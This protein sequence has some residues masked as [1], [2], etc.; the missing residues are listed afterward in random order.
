M[1]TKIKFSVI[2]LSLLL[3][4]L[5]PLSVM[6]ANAMTFDIHKPSFGLYCNNQNAEINGRIKYV[7]DADGN[8]VQHSEYTIN[9]TCNLDFDIPFISSLF[10]FPELDISV[11]GNAVTKEICYGEPYSLFNVEP[12]YNFY[13]PN[14]DGIMGTVYTLTAPSESFTVNF[15]TLD[16]QNFIYRFTNSYTSQ[17]G[18]GNFSYTINNAQ[19]NLTY[20]IFAINGEFAELETTAETVKETIPVKEYIDRNFAAMED[21]F[22]GYENA[23]PDLL[24]ALINN[25]IEK[26]I[27]YD[28]FNFF[29]DSFSKQRVNAY[30]VSVKSNDLPCI[31][32]YS[33]PVYVLTNKNFEPAIYLTEQTATGNYNLDYT[34]KLNSELPF[35]IESSAEI[36]KQSDYVYTAQNINDDFYFVFS[37]DKK[38][39]SIYNDSNNDNLRIILY[40]VV[41]VIVCALIIGSIFIF[42]H[43]KNPKKK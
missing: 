1:Q 30:K 15:K 39:K 12:S 41:G 35:I 8:A 10:D 40:V 21:Y 29:F 27:N 11:N 23:T 42:L 43:Y 33:M 16:N 14:I 13:S 25:A 7:I 3:L 17:R 18:N 9:G 26:S 2:F 5:F 36:K 4:A 22:S 31:I 19:P 32:S 6:T 28:F 20:E 37:S 24:Y 34:I 38:P